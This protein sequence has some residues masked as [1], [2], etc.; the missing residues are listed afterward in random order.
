MKFPLKEFGGRVDR[1]KKDMQKENFDALLIYADAWR[2]GDV[3]YVADYKPFNNTLFWFPSYMPAAGVLLPR[4]GDPTLFVSTMCI[5]EAAAISWIEEVKSWTELSACL[6]ELK[7][8]IKPR[9]FGITNKSFIPIPLYDSIAEKLG[10]PKIEE[11][12]IIVK[13]RAIKSNLEIKALKNAGE[14]ACV[15]MQTAIDETHEGAREVDI[16]RASEV[17]M[18]SHGGEGLGFDTIV[19]SGPRSALMIARPTERRIKD[20]DLVYVDLSGLYC[21]YASDLSRVMSFG[22]ISAEKKKM[23]ETIIYANEEGRK[24]IKPGVKPSEIHAIVNGAI[25]NAGYDFKQKGIHATGCEFGEAVPSCSGPYDVPL[26]PNMTFVVLSSIFIPR[27]GGGRIETL[28]VV[29]A[30]GARTLTPI[31]HV[32]HLGK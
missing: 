7:H 2:A 14:V 20:G 1:I 22:K 29:T 16:A 17:A 26:Q 15:G 18:L 8:E 3:R 28:M 6:E 25:T 31:E 5:D 9:K 13:L 11:T 27:V 23:L 21:G 19:G 32:L 4:E 30:T 10:R 12:D 24:A